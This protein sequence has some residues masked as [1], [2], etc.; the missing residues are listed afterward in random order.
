MKKLCC[1]EKGAK[2]AK[3]RAANK[4]NLQLHSH[5]QFFVTGLRAVHSGSVTFLDITLV[6]N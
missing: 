2:R 3:K 1:E 6:G 4:K 5:F